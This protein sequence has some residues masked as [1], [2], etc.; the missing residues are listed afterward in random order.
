MGTVAFNQEQQQV[1]QQ[2]LAFSSDAMR[3][4]GFNPQVLIN[5]QQSDHPQNP[6]FFIS[7]PYGVQEQNLLMPPHAK[8]QNRGTN[9]V[10]FSDTGQE[11]GRNLPLQKHKPQAMPQGLPYQLQLLP[12]YLQQRPAAG[13]KPKTV[14]GRGFRTS[15]STTATGYN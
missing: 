9:A 8:R 2:A 10:Q 14:G 13:L 15:L 1:M 7:L 11:F 5:Q 12:N 4:S 3:S 6:T